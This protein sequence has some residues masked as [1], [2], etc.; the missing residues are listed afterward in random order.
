MNKKISCRW[1]ANL[2]LAFAAMGLSLSLVTTARAQS[3]TDGAIGGTVFDQSGAVVPGASVTAHNNGTNRDQSVTTDASGNYVVIHVTPGIYTLTVTAKGFQTFK[4]EQVIV[5][6]GSVTTVLPHLT[7]G[8]TAQT[9]TISGAAPQINTTSADFAPTLNQTAISNLPINGGRWSN[10]A[11]LTPGVVSDANG[12]GLMSFRGISTLLN[13]NTVDGA[14]NNQAFFSEERGRTRIGYSSPKAAVQEF[15][16]NTSNYSAEYGRSAGGVVNTVTKSGTNEIHGEAYFYDRDNKWGSRNPFTTITT[17]TGPGTYATTAYKPVDVRKMTGFGVGGPLKKDKLFWFVAFDWHYRN[18]PGTSVATSPSAFYAS[19]SSA[20]ITTLAQRLSGLTTSAT[21]TAAQITTATNDYNNGVASLLA[22]NGPVPRTGKQDILLPKL[23]WQINQKNRASFEVNRMRWWSPAGIQT[24]ATN[25]YGIASFGNDYVADTWGVGKLDSILTPMISNEFRYQYGRDFEWEFPQG[26]TAFEKSNFITSPNFPGYTNPLGLPPDVFITNGFDMGVPTFLTR[27]RYPDEH[28]QQLADTIT[29]VHSNHTIKF[30]MDYTHVNDVSQNLRYQFGSFSYSSVANF[31]ADF[32]KPNNCG[33]TASVVG[34]SPCYS[35]YN[36]A[37]GP[38]G[39]NFSTQDIAL[40]GEDSW[41][42]M[43]HFTLNFGL[44]WDHEVLPTPTLV[45]SSVPQTGMFPDDKSDFGPR[46]GFAWDIFGDGKTSLRGGYG[47]Y[48]GRIIN[49][50]VYNALI[51]TGNSGGQFQY[52]YSGSSLT[53]GPAFP[54]ILTAPTGSVKPS[55]VFYGNNF[56]LPQVHETDLAL[57]RD[58][59]WN[60]VFSVSYL[61]SYGRHLPDFVDANLAPSTSTVTYNVSS[62]GPITASTYTT[63]L[64]TTR[65]NANYAA[66]SVIFAGINS[67]YNAL[68]LDV[69]HRLSHSIQFDVNYTFSHALDFGENATTFSDTN[70]LLDP[71]NMKTEYGNSLFNV[72][73]RLVM[74]AVINSPWHVK[75][76]AGWFANGWELAPIFQEQN[77]LPYSLVTSGTAPGAV[78]SGGGINGSNGRKGIDI[79]GRNSFK[80]PRT[81]VMDLRFSKKFTYKE[82]YGLELMAEGFNL[83]N[84]YNVTGVNNTGYVIS[85]SGTL[86][87]N[88]AVACSSASP[89]L[90]FNAP[91]GTLN[92]ANSNFVDGTRQIQLGLRLTF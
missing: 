16:V 76:T 26:P 69:K 73:N 74:D 92:N 10:F 17:S 68:V 83:F 67:N 42:V 66:M 27:P 5:S 54:E 4:A 18:F 57:E 40:F 1:F 34:T 70:D 79:V 13:N 65:P 2:L 48:Y 7:V 6:V 21:P 47:M 37:F 53:S 23:D 80:F 28:R 55:I 15:Q 88:S 51:N 85:T 46:I 91:F 36:Q 61:G 35:S 11:L 82:R 8:V 20:T 72:P 77:G 39:Y 90:N 24:Q 60:T 75:G 29:W 84:H 81:Q 50:A 44:R 86:A 56:K 59:G 49:S 41:K 25:T 22:E 45:N 14:D 62:G 71:F 38:L 87:S 58:L 64:Y 52:T 3:T 43:P 12:F 30:G 33:A 32:Y 31:V 9:V 89:C 63:K 19:P 78:S